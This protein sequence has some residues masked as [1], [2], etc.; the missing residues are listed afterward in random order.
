MLGRKTIKLS[1]LDARHSNPRQ[2]FGDGRYVTTR[3]RRLYAVFLTTDLET[4]RKGAVKPFRSEVRTD[5]VF[6]K[7]F[8]RKARLSPTSADEVAVLDRKSK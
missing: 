3:S 4:A 7:S 5:D 2:P 8:R 6:K 1:G